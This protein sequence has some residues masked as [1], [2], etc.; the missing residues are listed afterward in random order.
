MIEEDSSLSYQ[1]LA[2]LLGFNKNTVQ[3]IFQ[4]MGCQVRK[5][6]VG[7]LPRI[8]ALRPVASVPSERWTTDLYRSWA[9]RDG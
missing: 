1:T 9:G 5:R 2:S 7:R 4:L 6:P 3:R 8:E